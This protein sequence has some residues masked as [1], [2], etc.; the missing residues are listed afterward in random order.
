MSHKAFNQKL[1]WFFK[2][3]AI[4]FMLSFCMPHV[5]KPQGGV[6]DKDLPYIRELYYNHGNFN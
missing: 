6:P 2:N 1:F 5:K 4:I 3:L